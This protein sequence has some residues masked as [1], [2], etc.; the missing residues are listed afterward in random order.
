M[1]IAYFDCSS[2]IAG[3]MILGSLIDAG[4]PKKYLLDQLNKLNLK[5]WRLTI[6]KI[7][8]NHISAIHFNVSY[9][10]AIENHRNLADIASLTEKS[11]LSKSI[12]ILSIKI[13]TN[14][15][16]VEA[17]A[18]GMPINHVH[19]HEVGA[20]DS[21]IDIVGCAIGFDYFKIE[22]IYCSPINVGSGKIKTAHGVLPVPAPATAIL[23]KDMVSYA[24]DIKKELTTP[25][26]AAIVKTLIKGYGVMPKMMVSE[27][28]FGAGSYN[29][30]ELPN[31]LRVFI[32]S[33]ELESEHDTILQLE[34][35]IDDLDPK[36]YDNAIAGIMKSGALDVF[37]SP[38]RMKKGRNAILLTALCKPEEKDKI[39]EAIFTLTTTFGI[40]MYLAARE[41]LSKKMH[42][43]KYGKIKAGYLGNKLKT[44]AIEPDD[45]LALKHK[46]PTKTIYKTF[47]A[48][49]KTL[50][51]DKPSYTRAALAAVGK[52]IIEDHM[53]TC[54]TAS[55][56]KGSGEREIK[57]L[58]NVIEK[59]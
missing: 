58:L 14:L 3:N 34:A 13:F 44:L 28:G 30:K 42:K 39:I 17:Q 9:N 10:E 41:K 40:R 45:Y 59:F 51:L 48:S 37:V 24:S 55:I 31:V 16:K 7:N 20:I 4:L 19:F 54:V 6:N 2:G 35:N 36:L 18:H 22:E 8:K 11:K 56:R 52:R 21:I 57:E 53:K 25:T 43:T 32:G 46:V 27:V 49:A 15:A 26:G 5:N 33:K 29:I 1:K 50:K 38:I 12:K 23:L 47:A